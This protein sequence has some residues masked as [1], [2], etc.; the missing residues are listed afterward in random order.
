MLPLEQAR[1]L[2]AAGLAATDPSAVPCSCGAPR[3]K[4]AGRKHGGGCAETECTRYC[5]DMA[6]SLA[7]RALARAETPM[8]EDVDAHLRAAYPRSA[9]KRGGWRV[10]PSDA[11]NCRKRIWYRENPPE[12]LVLDEIDEGAASLGT[13]IHDSVARARAWRYP[14]LMIE[15]PVVVPGL[16]RRGRIDQYDPVLAKITDWKT[17]GDY[18]WDNLGEDGPPSGH[19]SQSLIYGKAL[20]A[21]GY[22]VE[23]VELEYLMRDDGRTETFR[24]PY[25][26]EA[27]DAALN[28]LLAINFALDMGQDLPRDRSGPS[29]DTLCARYCQFRSH[30]WNIPAAEK[31]G[32]SPEGYTILGPDPDRDSIAWAAEVAHGWQDQSGEAK[33]QKDHYRNLLRGVTPGRYGDYVVSQRSRVVNDE[34]RWKELVQSAIASGADPQQIAAIAVPKRREGPWPVVRKVRAAEL[35]RERKRKAA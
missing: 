17:A 33:K 35:E 29:S 16:D 15:F 20:I 27:A 6:Q 23:T 21:A 26:A 14:W 9:A 2:I 11:T 22:P 25:D 18:A 13:L 34:K 30:C 5:E 19:W 4:H 8:L 12:D 28:R 1:A 10:G 31:A 3:E 32:M 7:A 24:I